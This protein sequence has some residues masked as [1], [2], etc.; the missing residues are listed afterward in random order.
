ML[1]RILPV[2]LLLLVVPD[3]YICWHLLKVKRHLIAVRLAWW[4]PSIVLAVWGIWLATGDEFTP[5]RLAEIG[6]YMVVYFVVTIPKCLFALSSSI[7]WGVQILCKARV[8]Y[9]N[10][11]G[12]VLALIGFYMMFMGATFDRNNLQVRNVIF[13]S[14]DIP[15]SFDG[16]RIVQFSDLHVGTFRRGHEKDVKAIV[17]LINAQKGNIIVFT[18]DIVNHRAEELNGFEAQLSRLNAPDGVYSIM[19]NHDYSMY[20]HWKTEE[21]HQKAIRAIQDKERSL[22]WRLLLNE[23]VLLRRGNDSIALVGSE[24]DGYRHHFPRRGNLSKM[25]AGIEGLKVD[26]VKRPKLFKVLLSHDPTQW[27]R[28]ILP[29]SDIQLMLSGHTHGMQFEIFGFSP[30]E[31]LYPEWGGM[32]TVGSQSLYVSLGVGEVMI[33]FRFGA[34][35]EI[36]VITL[37]RLK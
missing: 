8:N 36:N 31:W 17:D 27:R 25:L 24:N 16:Y 9:G 2:L 3:T 11:A 10:Y 29:Q 34:L 13:T 35:P 28:K 1:E 14:P 32:Y 18:G 33:P 15:E 19:G 20:I 37:K 21:E 5:D 6:Q 23:H 26:T 22:G 7:G 30:A 4:V 12:G